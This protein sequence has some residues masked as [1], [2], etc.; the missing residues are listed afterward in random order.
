MSP[1]IN[2]TTIQPLRTSL[3]ARIRTSLPGPTGEQP[4]AARDQAE[5]ADGHPDDGE[6]ASGV[7]LVAHGLQVASQCKWIGHC[8]RE[9]QSVSGIHIVKTPRPGFKSLVDRRSL[10]VSHECENVTSC[11]C[12][13]QVGYVVSRSLVR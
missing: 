13:D 4:S 12:W 3:C 1:A 6:R 9:L 5:S 10:D 11:F 2:N 8:L 7:D